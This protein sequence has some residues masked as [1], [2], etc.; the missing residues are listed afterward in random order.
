MVGNAEGLLSSKTAQVQFKA[1]N[2][3]QKTSTLQTQAILAS[4][5]QKTWENSPQPQHGQFLQKAT[6][7]DEADWPNGETR[8]GRR[9]PFETV[10]STT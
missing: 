10:F 9:H 5:R 3:S 1:E 2:Q 8:T 4:H 6:Q 7:A